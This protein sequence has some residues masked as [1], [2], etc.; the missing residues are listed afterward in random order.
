MAALIIAIIS[1]ASFVAY[2]RISLA[3]ANFAGFHRNILIRRRLARSPTTSVAASSQSLST[4]PPS[5]STCDKLKNCGQRC[6]G[7]SMQY[8]RSLYFVLWFLLSSIF[9]L[10][11][12]SRRRLDVYHTSTRG[13]RGL[14]ANLARRSETCCTRL[15]EKYRTQKIAKNLTSAAHHRTTLSGSIFAT[16]AHVDKRKNLLS[17]NVS[18]TFPHNMVNFGLLPAEI[19]WRVWGTPANFKGFRVLAPLLHGTLVVGVSQTLWR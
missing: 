14:S 19:C 4:R 9:F 1:R 11:Y 12:F 10:A 3:R 6:Y 5:F 8:S 17:S 13:V 16:K 2:E 15:A 7:C 18:P